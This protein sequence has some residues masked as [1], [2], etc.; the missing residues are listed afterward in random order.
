MGYVSSIK[1]K[2]KEL[3][4]G[5]FEEKKKELLKEIEQDPNNLDWEEVPNPN[6]VSLR[7]MGGIYQALSFSEQP[8]QLVGIYE[9]DRLRLKGRTRA[10]MGPPDIGP[11]LIMTGQVQLDPSQIQ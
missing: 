10:M 7:R 8:Q 4:C 5:E 6:N 1:V 2:F 11:Q 9:P 3:S